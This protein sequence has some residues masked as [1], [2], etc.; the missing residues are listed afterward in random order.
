LDKLRLQDDL[1]NACGRLEQIK[2]VSIEVEL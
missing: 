1:A 2:Q